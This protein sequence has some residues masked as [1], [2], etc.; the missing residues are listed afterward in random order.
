MSGC[1]SLAARYRRYAQQCLEMAQVFTTE[2]ARAALLYMAQG[3]QRLADQ[4]ERSAPSFQ[5]QQQIQPK[6]RKNSDPAPE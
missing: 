2:Q 1:T 5:Q 3:W 4:H 6:S